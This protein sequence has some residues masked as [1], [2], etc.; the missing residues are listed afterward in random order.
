MG[1]L[2]LGGG[3]DGDVDG[4]AVFLLA[5]FIDHVGV[6]LEGAAGETFVGGDG[7]GGHAVAVEFVGGFHDG[8]AFFGF[9]VEVGFGDDGELDGDLAGVVGDGGFGKDF[10]A[11]LEAGGRDGAGFVGEGFEFAEVGG[12]EFAALDGEGGD[13]E[14]RGDGEFTEM[15][16]RDRY[17]NL[18]M[19]NAAFVPNA[20]GVL[21]GKAFN[22]QGANGDGFPG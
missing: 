14:E 7:E 21:G 1:G 13:G 20:R 16:H 11:G 19:L 2:L 17:W 15:V 3:G 8:G 6:D 5:V 22:K 4:F 12:A 9:A 10:F 18:G